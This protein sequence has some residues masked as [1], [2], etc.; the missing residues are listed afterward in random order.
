MQRAAA[1]TVARTGLASA[2]RFQPKTRRGKG[3]RKKQAARGG[4]GDDGWPTGRLADPR[5]EKGEG[6]GQAAAGL[7]QGS[8]PKRG[9]FWVFSY[10]LFSSTLS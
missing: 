6:E 10:F 5:R 9:G 8:R 4:G 3:G 2:P 7:C 1:K